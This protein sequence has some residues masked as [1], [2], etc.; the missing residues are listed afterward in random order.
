MSL[1]F[2]LYNCFEWSAEL[3]MLRDTIDNSPRTT[4]IPVTCCVGGVSFDIHWKARWKQVVITTRVKGIEIQTFRVNHNTTP[5]LLIT[6]GKPD[7]GNSELV[8]C[9]P[10]TKQVQWFYK[11]DDKMIFHN[12]PLVDG[13]N[14]N[15][16]GS[17][18]SHI[19]FTR[20]LLRIF[21]W[22]E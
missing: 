13:N 15:L 2:T 21:P 7:P 20:M 3:Y 9:L 5:G 17:H 8:N 1:E 19:G 22:L 10:V 14:Q 6:T 4:G 16:S 12:H 18:L 11:E